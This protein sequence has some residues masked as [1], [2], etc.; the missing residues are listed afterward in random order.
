[1]ID[2]RVGSR[3]GGVMD[4]QDQSKG[5]IFAPRS[6]RDYENALAVSTQ[7][8]QDAIQAGQSDLRRVVGAARSDKQA[9]RLRYR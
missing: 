7:R 9:T 1:V 2:D 6:Q 5:E 4:D 8:L 3:F